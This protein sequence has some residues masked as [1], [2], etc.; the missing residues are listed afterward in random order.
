[1][2]PQLVNELTTQGEIALVLD[3]FHCVSAGLARESVAWLIEHGPPSFQALVSSRT[4]R[5]LPPPRLPARGQ[6]VEGR[7]QDPAVTADEADAGMNGRMN[8]Q[9]GTTRWAS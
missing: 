3:D 1:M 2:P 5:S 8:L 4:E 6:L 7:A 9:L